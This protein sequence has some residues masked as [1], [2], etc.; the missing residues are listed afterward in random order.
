[1][2][3]ALNPLLLAVHGRFDAARGARIF[4]RHLAKRGAGG[5]LLLQGGSDWPSRSK[6]SGA[7][8]DLSNLVVTARKDSAASR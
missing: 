7:F 1:M 6:A 3:L 8:A 4:P 5:L 2:L